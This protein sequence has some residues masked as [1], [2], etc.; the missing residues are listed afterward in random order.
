MA[1]NEDSELHL[2]GAT[3][4][5]DVYDPGDA[6]PGDPGD[7]APQLVIGGKAMHTTSVDPHRR[8]TVSWPS[9][10]W[11]DEE[12]DE[13]VEANLTYTSWD[14]WYEH[15]MDSTVQWPGGKCGGP[16]QF[17]EEIGKLH[18]TTRVIVGCQSVC[19]VDEPVGTVFTSMVDEGPDEVLWNE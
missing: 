3:A 6:N 19:G 8:R 17:V 14:D 15:A 18:V 2:V 16:T 9:W 10:T 12:E 7:V 1:F 11:Y 4:K 5:S 13:V